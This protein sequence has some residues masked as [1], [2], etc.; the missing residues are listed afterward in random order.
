[1]KINEKSMRNQ[2]NIINEKS[3]KLHEHWSS[4]PPKKPMKI[5]SAVSQRSSGFEHAPVLLSRCQAIL[6]S[7]VPILMDDPRRESKQQKPRK[8]ADGA[9]M[10]PPRPLSTRR[11]VQRLVLSLWR[12]CGIRRILWPLGV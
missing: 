7:I 10:V 4:P 8:G 6:L 5:I 1:M 9:G 3:M 12:S 2:W 11:V